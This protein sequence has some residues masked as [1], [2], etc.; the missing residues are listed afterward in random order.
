[1][2]GCLLLHPPPNPNDVIPTIF[3]NNEFDGNVWSA[4]PLKIRQL[5]PLSFG[6]YAHSWLLLMP[7]RKAGIILSLFKSIMVVLH[8]DNG[9]AWRFDLRICSD[10]WICWPENIYQIKFTEIYINC[11]FYSFITPAT[12][13]KRFIWIFIEIRFK[14]SR[15]NRFAKCDRFREPN[16]CYIVFLR[17]CII[18]WM[19]DCFLWNEICQF[20]DI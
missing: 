10:R 5:C 12:F 18:I 4:P 15:S 14:T 7:Y 2:P 17:S 11:Q 8:C 9:I 3:G 19:H 20:D 16:Q 13:S 1:M 6:S